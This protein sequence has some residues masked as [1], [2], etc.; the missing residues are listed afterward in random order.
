MSDLL[1]LLQ[2]ALGYLH[3]G[4]FEDATEELEALP[5]EL[6]TS[7]E[8]LAIRA[9][10]FSQAGSWES[11]REIASVLVRNWPDD[12]GHWI[13]LAYA[14]RRCRDIGEAES[15]L[16]TASERHDDEPLIHFNLACY[17]AQTGK[18]EAARKSLARAIALDEK[19]RELAI[20]D[21][22]LDPL[23]EDA[24]NRF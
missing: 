18:F 7:R 8:V 20:D 16:L 22:D 3:L 17:A 6:K 14:T 5:A 1:A 2:S 10:I 11:M 23:W 21:P 4:L 9:D 13:S 15:I 24:E 19:I 12:A